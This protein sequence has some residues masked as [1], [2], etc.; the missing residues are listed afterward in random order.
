M[1]LIHA[2]FMLLVLRYILN[3][4]GVSSREIYDL[5]N[6]IENNIK[7]GKITGR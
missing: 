5:C 2:R 6:D 1:Q 7:T 4:S 3:Q